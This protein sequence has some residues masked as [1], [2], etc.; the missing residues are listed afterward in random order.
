MK[1]SITKVKGGE[2]FTNG[3][4]VISDQNMIVLV[5]IKNI[6]TT[7]P[8]GGIVVHCETPSTIGMTNSSWNPSHFSRFHGTI[9]IEV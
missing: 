3:D 5:T 4:Y 7:S 9:T 2:L 1:T 6:T 8:F